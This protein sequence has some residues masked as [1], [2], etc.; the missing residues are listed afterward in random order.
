M[1]EISR[2][3]V[4]KGASV[5]GAALIT[6]ATI[7][8]LVTEAHAATLVEPQRIFSKE[9]VLTATLEVKPVMV[10]YNGTKRWALGYNGQVPGPT[11][12][13]KPG[14]TLKIKVKNSFTQ[15]TN[16]HTHGLHVPPVVNGD[17]PF[18]MINPKKSFDYVIKIPANH[19]SGTFWYHPHHHEFVAKQIHAGLAGA[20]IVQDKFDAQDE[21]K[22]LTDRVMIFADP[23]IG[24]DSSVMDTSMMDQMHGR[25]GPAV[26]I[27]GQPNPTLNAVAG[28][29]ERWRMLNASP[30]TYVDVTVENADLYVVGTDGGRI[31]KPELVPGI[32]MTP[33]QRYEVIVKPRKSGALR[34]F[35]GSNVIGTLNAQTSSFISLDKLILPTV[36]VLKPTAKRTINITGSGMMNMGGGMGNHEMSFQF[37]GKSFD[38]KVINQKAKVG[39][40]EEWTITNKSGMHHPF[41]IH[42][43]DFQVTDRGDGSPMFGWHDTVNIPSQTSVKFAITFADFGGKT[44]YHCH[45]LDHEDGG[46]MGIIQVS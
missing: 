36:P 28:K 18:I 33:G 25:S 43:W 19:K 38:P 8:T 26:L 6:P 39:T 40:V 30:S 3:T 46:M 27:N 2:R 21:F 5:F 45:I 9:G 41:H 7:R 32:N 17:N 37:D 22:K 10:S 11:L 44:V 16:L 15:M 34:I 35:N 12:V 20:I 4:I 31:A 1:S 29:S 24:S 14:D 13:V 42:A 23:R